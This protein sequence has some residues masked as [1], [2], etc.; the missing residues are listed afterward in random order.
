VTVTG[1]RD[2]VMVTVTSV[3]SLLTYSFPYYNQIILPPYCMTKN[4]LKHY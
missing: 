3:T 1:D 4:Q 2:W